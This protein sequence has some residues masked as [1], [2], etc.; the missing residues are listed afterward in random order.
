MQ[1][2]YLKVTRFLI[3]WAKSEKPRCIGG[4]FTVGSSN[5]LATGEFGSENCLSIKIGFG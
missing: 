4:R 1:N 5:V 3:L 2:A